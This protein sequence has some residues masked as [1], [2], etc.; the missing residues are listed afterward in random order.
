VTPTELA[1]LYA[2]A[3]SSNMIAAH[4][5]AITLARAV[6]ELDAE[7]QRYRQPSVVT[8][9]YLDALDMPSFCRYVIAQYGENPDG[10]CAHV[11]MAHYAL[12]LTTR[13]TALKEALV[14]ACEIADE[15]GYGHG[16][17]PAHRRITALRA[18]AE[19]P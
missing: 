9:E 10:P 7:V 14:E 13:I 1:S 15:L 19:E 17:R 8:R 18:I 2:D 12:T 4:N 5:D 11:R 16:D 3:Q 6:L